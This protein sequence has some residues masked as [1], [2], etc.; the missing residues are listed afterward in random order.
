MLLS[1]FSFICPFFYLNHTLISI[2]NGLGKTLR[3]FIHNLLAVLIRIS[4]T[5]FCV[6]LYG[7]KGYLWGILLSE[8][9]T[10]VLNLVALRPTTIEAGAKP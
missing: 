6:P 9:L 4:F 3:S 2:L 1:T 5:F 8:L 7:I 10:A